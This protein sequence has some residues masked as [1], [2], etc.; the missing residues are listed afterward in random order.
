M[1]RTHAYTVTMT[2]ATCQGRRERKK[3]ATRRAIRSAALRLALEHGVD[4][5]TVEDVSEAADV[6]PRTFFNYFASKEDALVGEDT[7]VTAELREALDARPADEPPLRTL[8]V[9]LRDRTV[10]HTDQAHREEALARQRLVKENPSLLPRQLAK[11]AAVER[12]L[13]EAMAN[14]TGSD[15]E[16][17]LRPALLAALA[18]TVMRVAMRRW[19]VD[20]TSSPGV[21]VDEA[22]DL[23]ERGL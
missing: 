19:S 5:F 8:R 20:E 3:Q 4:G 12:T 21:L 2:E 18:V 23:V 10:A 13:T 15:P 14:R 11:F 9:V 1:L 16:Q 22:F 6:A 7:E 17:E